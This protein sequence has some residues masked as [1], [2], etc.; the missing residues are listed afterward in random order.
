MQI[1]IDVDEETGRAT[2]EMEGAEPH[3]CESLAECL[4]YIEQAMGAEPAEEGAEMDDEEAA[5]DMA[6]MWDEE[7]AR[8][9]A[10]PGLMR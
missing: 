5:P 8:R 4:D 6:A 3:E 2:V 7:A 1:I 9:P 10:Q